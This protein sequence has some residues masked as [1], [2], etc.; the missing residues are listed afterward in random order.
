MVDGKTTIEGKIV[1]VRG[2]GVELFFWITQPDDL[3]QSRHL[4]GFFYESDDLQLLLKHVKQGGVV[5]D[6][7]SHIGNH[8]IFFEKLL[9]AREIILIEPN[10]AIIDHLQ[11]NIGLNR[12]RHVDESFL[13]LGLGDEISTGAMRYLLNN[14]AAA[15]FVPNVERGTV[16]IVPGD[17]LFGQRV[18]D[19]I[20]IDVEGMEMQV[21]RGLDRVI[22]RCAPDI[23]IEV[24]ESNEHR[25]RDWCSAKSYH[26]VAEPIKYSDYK[27]HLVRHAP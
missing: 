25:F 21:L 6:V 9:F 3:V 17:I 15:E 11:I 2:R 7:G 27:N 19:F 8:A 13:G 16:Q 18:I 12:L 26:P 22:S 23:H 14:A 24:R 20:K 10:P 1:R 4:N 5:L